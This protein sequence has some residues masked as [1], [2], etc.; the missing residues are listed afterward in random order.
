MREFHPEARLAND[1]KLTLTLPAVN[2][3]RPT[4]FGTVVRQETIFRS[5]E[6]HS[7]MLL[8]FTHTD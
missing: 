6:L 8:P 7:Y 3:S 1:L 4:S 2:D 5:G